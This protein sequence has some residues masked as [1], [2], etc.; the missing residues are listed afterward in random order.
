MKANTE[1]IIDLHT[2]STGSDGSLTPTEL[3]QTAREAGL[4]A[5]ALTD[6]DS[7]AGQEEFKTAGERFGVE[8]VPGVELSTEY[9]DEEIHVVGL[10]TDPGCEALLAQLKVFRDNRDGR[11]L[12]MIKKLRETGFGI[13]AEELYAR[14]PDSVVARPHMARYLVETG[15]APDV[16][17]VF[18]N[19]IADGCPC[20]V[21]RY[22]ITPMEAVELIRE[23][24]GLSILAHPC[25]YKLPYETLIMM[26]TEMK[27][28]GLN[29]IEAVYSRNKPGDEESFRRIAT[30][31]GLLLSGGSDF[32]GASKPDIHL[33]DLHVPYGFLEK[34]KEAHI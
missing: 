11:N 27:A 3:V 4:S 34:I 17:Y 32:H 6:H 8:T 1:R 18:D 2:H 24:G 15:Q 16:K 30:D 26:V 19:Y 9:A 29:G 22:K 25:L 13:T 28:V 7:V 20:Y 10:F 33:G 5:I 21:E 31:F 12:K 23:A 14:Y